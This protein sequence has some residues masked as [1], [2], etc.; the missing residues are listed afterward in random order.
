M[1]TKVGVLAIMLASVLSFNAFAEG[2]K[3]VDGDDVTAALNDDEDK[4]KD[5]DKDKS[6]AD[7][8]EKADEDKKEASTGDGD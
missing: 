2:D 7:V 8:I 5:K 4:D 1:L 3:K 6:D